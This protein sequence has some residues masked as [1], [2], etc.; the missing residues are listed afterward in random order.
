MPKG[1]F[2]RLLIILAGMTACLFITIMSFHFLT[3][4]D[5][6]SY[7]ATSEAFINSII[8]DGA[9]DVHEDSQSVFQGVRIRIRFTIESAELS[10]FL[11]DY[12]SSNNLTVGDSYV[13]LP[14]ID[15]LE[16]WRPDNAENYISGNCW[17]DNLQLS[18]LIDTTNPPFY[19][20][21]FML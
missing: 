17:R 13:S 15:D 3:E 19:V 12:C 14:E 7:V 10:T 21:Y 11:D 4:D 20:I 8:P 18:M 2:R 5:L 1:K 9:T 6:Q 16:W